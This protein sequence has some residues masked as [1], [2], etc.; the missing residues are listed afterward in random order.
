MEKK[1]LNILRLHGKITELAFFS[2]NRTPAMKQ[3]HCGNV[4]KVCAEVLKMDNLTGVF[5]LPPKL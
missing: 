5:Y 3:N 1:K 4:V 2:A